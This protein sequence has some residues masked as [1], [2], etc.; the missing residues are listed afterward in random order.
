MLKLIGKTHPAKTV[1][2]WQAVAD[3][4]RQRKLSRIKAEIER[5]CAEYVNK[6]LDVTI[7]KL[8]REGKV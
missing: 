2:L 3:N 1:A 8:L 4:E 7:E 6:R 5:D